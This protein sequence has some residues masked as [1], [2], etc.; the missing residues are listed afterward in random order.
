MGEKSD[1]KAIDAVHKL[2]WR[3][4]PGGMG[5]F[6]GSKRYR[7]VKY[8]WGG[9]EYGFEPYPTMEAAQAAAQRD[10]AVLVL[11]MASFA[12]T[13]PAKENECHG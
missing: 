7:F 5:G 4:V 9:P 1:E 13:R 6:I 10:F 12:P 11:E 3:E 8:G 2:E